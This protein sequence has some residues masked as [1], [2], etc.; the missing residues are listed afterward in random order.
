MSEIDLV[1]VERQDLGL[2]VATLELHR[3]EHFLHLA[4][5]ER[6]PGSHE[7]TVDHVLVEEETARE[8][9]R[10]GARPETLAVDDVLDGGDD[11]ARDAQPEVLLEVAVFAGDDGLTEHGRHVV[12]ADDD[13]A[14]DR[15]LADDALVA[16]Q[17]A[18]D[19]VR[20]IVVERA[21]FRNVVGEREEHAADSPEHGRD[22]EERDQAGVPCD[23]QHDLAPRLDGWRR[24]FASVIDGLVVERAHLFE[25]KT[26]ILIIRL[27]H[28]DSVTLR[29]DR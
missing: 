23:A 28:G 4:L 14:L 26:L 2:R 3:H 10:N 9:L 1:G 16:S 22:D 29:F 6:P 5:D 19:R 11:D 24:R 18:G 25:I 27:A 17:Q 15:E 13:A 12:V 21:D 8:L 20:L 7:H